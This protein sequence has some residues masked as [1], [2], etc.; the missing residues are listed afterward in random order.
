MKN[1]RY[2]YQN[3][4]R[5]KA[6]SA[7]VIGNNGFGYAKTFTKLLLSACMLAGLVVYPTDVKGQTQEME[8]DVVEPL[9][10]GFSEDFYWVY[11]NTNME[12]IEIY[13]YEGTEKDIVIPSELDGKTVTGIGEKVFSGRNDI[14]SVTIPDSVT[15]IGQSAFLGCEGLSSVTIPASVTNIK[16][17]AFQKCTNLN[18]IT[19][20]NGVTDIGDYAFSICSSL[21]NVELPDSV[22]SI[23][24]GAFWQDTGL[25][26]ITIGSKVTNIGNSAFSECSSLSSIIIP[27][28]VTDIG[29]CCLS[30]RKRRCVRDS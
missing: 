8:L 30:C 9:A 28:S 16:S 22:I 14:K 19:L 23:G 13:G 15:Y 7:F 12:T 11:N 24:D 1:P 17:Y 20:E 2:F 25:S 5:R 21:N 29:S 10:P 6:V 26:N 3:I 27:E 4:I 18:S